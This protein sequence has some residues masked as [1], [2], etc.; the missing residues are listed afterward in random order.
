MGP[1]QYKNMPDDSVQRREETHT[2]Q[3]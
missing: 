2:F 1:Y 3:D